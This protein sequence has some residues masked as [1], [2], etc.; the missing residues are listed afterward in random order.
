MACEPNSLSGC[1]EGYRPFAE[2]CYRVHATEP[3]NREQALAMCRDEGAELVSIE[4]QV[5]QW[6]ESGERV[7]RQW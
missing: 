2:S 1:P 5:R 4:T 7:M 6:R 3:K